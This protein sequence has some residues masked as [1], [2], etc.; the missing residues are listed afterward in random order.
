M[1]REHELALIQV[2]GGKR[3]HW[4]FSR[5]VTLCGLHVVMH[6]SSK[7][8]P[9]GLPLCKTCVMMAERPRKRGLG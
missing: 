8:A 1:T 2:G 6:A 9:E 5:R 4:S 3:A 7:S